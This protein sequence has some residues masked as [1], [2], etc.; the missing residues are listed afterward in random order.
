MLEFGDI[1]NS[2]SGFGN[3]N[4]G[5]DYDKVYC[6][7][8]CYNYIYFSYGEN[9]SKDKTKGEGSYFFTWQEA[10]RKRCT[11]FD[12]PP[13]YE[14][15]CNADYAQQREGPFGQISYN[16]KMINM[17]KDREPPKKRCHQDHPLDDDGFKCCWDGTDCMYKVHYDGIAGKHT[18]TRT[19]TDS[20]CQ[21][22]SLCALPGG[23]WIVGVPKCVQNMIEDLIE[24]IKDV[25]NSRDYERWLIQCRPL[26]PGMAGDFGL[27][28]D[29]DIECLKEKVS[30]NMCERFKEVIH[31]HLPCSCS[32]NGGM[33]GG[34]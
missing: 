10:K 11:D 6:Q 28:G 17:G 25:Y 24:V 22:Q 29:V 4:G 8:E 34:Y 20:E 12:E 18:V 31:K 7:D 1:G 13:S 26:L 5:D 9:A 27:K 15:T 33:G 21:E 32:P 23:G 3:S 19:Q 14:E 2:K 16:L 30:D